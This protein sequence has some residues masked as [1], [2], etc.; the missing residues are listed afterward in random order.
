MNGLCS[1]F[2]YNIRCATELCYAICLLV[3]TTMEMILKCF[4]LFSVQVL[5]NL[6][7][8]ISDYCIIFLNDQ[9]E[10]CLAYIN[11]EEE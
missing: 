9:Q 8:I 10:F 7:S 5:F 4:L 1:S 2:V 11:R 3:T 6:V